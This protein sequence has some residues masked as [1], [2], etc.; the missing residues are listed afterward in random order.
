MTLSREA[1]LAKSKPSVRRINVPMW[2]DDVYLR[3][4]TVGERN[5]WAAL[6]YAALEGDTLD[7]GKMVE[8]RVYL[9]AVSLCDADGKPLFSVEELKETLRPDAVDYL[10]NEAEKL[11]GLTAGAVED[12][13]G[14]SSS[15]QDD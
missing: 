13:E 9:V 7:F 12:L 1:I 14:N 4:I 6:R 10:A 11:N 2:D 5:E 8:S 15:P 3:D